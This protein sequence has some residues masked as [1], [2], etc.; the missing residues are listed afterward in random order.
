MLNKLQVHYNNE[1]CLP[2]HL[3][4]FSQERLSVKN[5]LCPDFSEKACLIGAT[6]LAVLLLK[7]LNNLSMWS[8]K[9]AVCVASSVEMKNKINK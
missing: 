2:L 6:L 8:R 7:A 1:N 4:V 9:S 3:T 5:S